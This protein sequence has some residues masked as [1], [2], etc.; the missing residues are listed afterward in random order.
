MESGCSPDSPECRCPCN[1]G[2]QNDPNGYDLPFNESGLCLS[3]SKGR[4]EIPPGELNE[5]IILHEQILNQ[6]KLE[7]LSRNTYCQLKMKQWDPTK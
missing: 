7:D 2:C 5:L 1:C 4:H 6:L 3:C